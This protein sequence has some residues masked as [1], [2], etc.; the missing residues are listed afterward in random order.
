MS[1]N[2]SACSRQSTLPL[3]LLLDHVAL[4]PNVFVRAEWEYIQFF[5]VQDF[6]IHIATGRVG[7]GVKF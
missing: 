2:S 4:L 1:V 3:L 6:K 5:P 7:V